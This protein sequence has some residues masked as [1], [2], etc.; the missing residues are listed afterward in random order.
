MLL[1]F[2]HIH[3]ETQCKINILKWAKTI[4]KGN[5][6]VNLKASSGDFGD[7]LQGWGIHSVILGSSALLGLMLVGAIFASHL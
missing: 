1:R 6:F 2:S 7:F 4:R 3:P 5:L